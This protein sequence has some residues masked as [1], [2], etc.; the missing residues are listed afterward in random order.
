M[1][2]DASVAVN[3]NLNT[4]EPRRGLLLCNLEWIPLATKECYRSLSVNKDSAPVGVETTGPCESYNAL[5][6]QQAQAPVN[7]LDTVET[8]R[9][10]F[11]CLQDS[12]DD[13]YHTERQVRP[14]EPRKKM[15]HLTLPILCRRVSSPE[16]RDARNVCND[17]Q[18]LSVAEDTPTED[19][20]F[21][22]YTVKGNDYDETL[23]TTSTTLGTRGDRQGTSWTEAGSWSF[24]SQDDMEPSDDFQRAQ[25]GGKI[26][27]PVYLAQPFRGN[28]QVV[29]QIRHAAAA[30][31]FCRSISG[32]EDEHPI[33][34]KQ[35][36]RIN[37]MPMLHCSRCEAHPSSVPTAAKSLPIRLTRETDGDG[38][39]CLEATVNDDVRNNLA[40]QNRRF[41]TKTFTLSRSDRTICS[42]TSLTQS[43][44]NIHFYPGKEYSRREST[45]LGRYDLRAY[46]PFIFSPSMRSCWCDS[47]SAAHSSLKCNSTETLT[48]SRLPLTT[49]EQDS[50]LS[51]YSPHSA[52]LPVKFHFLE[53]GCIDFVGLG[54]ST[55]VS[56]IEDCLNTEGHSP[57]SVCM[58]RNENI[59]QACRRLQRSNTDP[60]Y[61]SSAIRKA[62]ENTSAFFH[63]CG[64]QIDQLGCG[65]QHCTE[66]ENDSF[67]TQDRVGSFGYQWRP[68]LRDADFL[69]P[70]SQSW[71]E[72]ATD[73]WRKRLV[74]AGYLENK[75]RSM[76]C[77]VFR[78]RMDRTYL[79][80]RIPE[81]IDASIPHMLH[82]SETV[83]RTPSPPAFRSHRLRPHTLTPK[84]RQPS[85]NNRRYSNSVAFTN[86]DKK[87]M[88]LEAVNV[89]LAAGP[90]LRT[91]DEML[92][93]KTLSEGTSKT[94]AKIRFDISNGDLSQIPSGRILA[95]LEFQ[96]MS[97]ILWKNQI[98]E[99]L[100]IIDQDQP[101][102]LNMFGMILCPDWNGY[103]S[104][105]CTAEPP[106][107]FELRKTWKERCSFLNFKLQE[108]VWSHKEDCATR[109]SNSRS[110]TLSSSFLHPLISYHEEHQRDT[111]LK[112]YTDNITEQ[113]S[114]RVAMLDLKRFLSV[115]WGYVELRWIRRVVIGL[116]QRRLIRC[117]GD[118]ASDFNLH[119]SL[120]DSLT[121]EATCRNTD[122][123][124]E[125][126]PI[127]TEPHALLHL[128]AGVYVYRV[129][130]IEDFYVLGPTLGIGGEGHV[131]ICIP[132][133][134]VRELGWDP[135]ALNWD[136]V[137]RTAREVSMPQP[138][139]YAMKITPRTH[140]S[141]DV[142][143]MAD[144]LGSLRHT[145]VLHY[146]ALYEDATNYFVLMDL[147]EGPELL[148]YLTAVRF[149]TEEQCRNLFS[150]V[151]R[152]LEYIHKQQLIHRDVK[153]ENFVCA[154][155]MKESVSR[156]MLNV[157][158]TFKDKNAWSRKD[159]QC[160]G[161]PRLLLIDFGLACYEQ[162]ASSVRPNGTPLYMAPELLLGGST[163]PFS[164]H[165]G[166][167]IW[168]SGIM[169]CQL[170][171]GRTPFGPAGPLSQ[172]EKIGSVKRRSGRKGI[173]GITLHAFPCSVENTQYKGNNCGVN[174]LY[175]NELPD[176]DTNELFTL[177]R[178]GHKLLA[179]R[180]FSQ[181]ASDVEL[182][183]VQEPDDIYVKF[184]VENEADEYD[185]DDGDVSSTSSEIEIY[186][187]Q[188]LS[189]EGDEWSHVSDEAKDLVRRLLT[190]D[191]DQRPTAEEA[192]QHPWF[193]VKHDRGE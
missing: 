144:C 153:L 184:Y 23:E 9:E 107:I 76:K 81:R 37:S 157:D 170:L 16:E 78:Q 109:C 80:R 98:L 34:D 1:S 86:F 118:S 160:T 99:Q 89:T 44:A 29:K 100:I 85:S 3:R 74:R 176:D 26:H 148:E 177:V 173:Q 75:G 52:T 21:F 168:A 178:H 47:T 96:N 60:L 169:L 30:Q 190:P 10:D 14:L 95:N 180:P 111:T 38:N 130:R 57:R 24:E 69:R 189:F 90:L 68:S 125:T 112:R 71:K 7:A 115:D 186:R 164:Y 15:P 156:E 94:P 45:S 102:L 185:V 79:C 139:L 162:D 151:L 51:G 39:T 13:M 116:L 167:D 4:S 147:A 119:L 137:R 132:T 31:G 41:P 101:L 6:A 65:I 92:L 136:I 20:A 182:K 128:Y 97:R 193:G 83:L 58:E 8:C 188:R 87:K 122:S 54:D 53:H 33:R 11:K 113:E 73:R 106:S 48:S 104:T 145:N 146:L 150:Q 166:V 12:V 40:L 120:Q 5:P 149:V 127:A 50:L 66:T 191:P 143:A 174:E 35:D 43:G 142:Y 171:S 17:P 114:L 172:I 121:N 133:Q 62:L 163:P 49:Q 27:R 154:E 61:C 28:S 181:R 46:F 91:D 131:K 19:D 82:C 117:A 64:H 77:D 179:R 42:A 67:I 103:V 123:P 187:M 110:V 192:L 129:D 25:T 140:W 108:K 22:E 124:T 72:L 88:G 18:R 135:H 55:T 70:S 152:A 161:V 84:C 138:L 141:S 134:V 183:E 93:N 165:K 36:E 159:S 2:S 56:C 175:Q 63:H 105:S 126:L 155:P 59:W 32:L 158:E